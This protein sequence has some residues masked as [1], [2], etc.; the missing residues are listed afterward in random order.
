MGDVEDARYVS[1]GTF[2]RSGVSVDTPVWAAPH[3]GKLYVFTA[4]ES[5][6]V[7]RLRN[8]SKARVAPC[9]VRGHLLGA[10]RDARATIVESPAT[11]EAAYV[12]LRRKYGWQMRLTDAL[13][14]LSGRYDRRIILEIE[15]L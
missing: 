15:P 4:G 12:A 3:A 9:D 5:G 6:K 1:L 2:R 11:I 10:W 14:R 7:K 13:S 8:S